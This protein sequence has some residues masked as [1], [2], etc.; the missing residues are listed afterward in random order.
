MR[1]GYVFATVASC[2]VALGQQPEC[3]AEENGQYYDLTPLRSKATDYE[4]TSDTGRIFKLNV[5]AAVN[6]EPWKMPNPASVGAFYRGA[7]SDV[8][9]GTV[10]TSL[11]IKDSHPLL[12]LTDGAPCGEN[13]NLHAATAVRFICD[14]D[15][16]GVGS[17]QLVA[18]LPPDDESSCAFF[19]EWR[20]HVACPTA[21]PSGKGSVIAILAAVALILLLSYIVAGV[22]YR[23]FALG[24]RGFDQFPR[25]SLIPISAL[26]HSFADILDWFRDIRDHIRGGASDLWPRS[27]VN[28]GP[29]SGGWTRR[30]D[31]FSALARE[32][33]EAMFRDGPDG[34]DPR[35]SVED[36]ADLDGARELV[37][38]NPPVP[39]EHANAGVA[40]IRL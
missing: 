21:A 33:E 10:N 15:V 11:R 31:G 40:P 6:S 9:I 22:L 1:A 13:N 28:G 14:N 20:T 23:R 35:F 39:A 19:F 26:P 30:H 29:H 24:Y 36:E 18:Q 7:H 2:Y 32:E 3:T 38:S 34:P 4:F 25:I 27:N 12:V 8:S 16:F 17:P 5:C 37:D